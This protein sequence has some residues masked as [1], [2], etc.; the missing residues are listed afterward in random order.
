[1]NRLLLTSSFLLLTFLTFAKKSETVNT[2]KHIR[3]SK[4]KKEIKFNNDRHS[5]ALIKINSGN[6]FIVSPPNLVYFEYTNV[7]EIAEKTAGAG[8][9]VFSIVEVKVSG[10]NINSPQTVTFDYSSST[11]TIDE[12]FSTD[13]TS[14]TFDKDGT[15]IITL[16]IFND[17]IIEDTESIV[18]KFD[19][20]TTDPVQNRIAN[21]IITDDDYVPTIGIAAVEVS[22]EEFESP[23][24]PAGWE[25][26]SILETEPNVW[27]FDG[28]T[29]DTVGKAYISAG[30]AADGATYNSTA[31]GNLILISDLINAKGFTNVTISFD[32][33]AGG[34]T[35][36]VD[37]ES[38]FD[39][40]TFVY[41]YDGIN[42]ISMSNFA[43]AASG[44][45]PSSGNYNK[46]ITELDDAQF[47]LGWRWINDDL[48]GTSFSFTI[49]NVVVSA[50]PA[51]VAAV[52]DQSETKRVKIGSQIY[53]LDAEDGD[54][55]GMIENAD[56]DLNCVTLTVSE[57]GS[58]AEF[59]NIGGTHSGK[60]IK[61]ETDAATASYDLTLF[62]TDAEVNQLSGNDLSVIK[63]KVNGNAIDDAS[64]SANNF[65][66]STPETMVY[67]EHEYSTYKGT[68][69]G[70]GTYALMVEETLSTQSVNADEFKIYPTVL[71]ADKAI[72]IISNKTAID[73]VDIY[74]INGTLMSSLELESRNKAQVAVSKLT[75]GMYFLVINSNRTDSYKFLIK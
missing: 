31:F 30:V 9:D 32:W 43:G 41:S 59:T 37:S 34:E 51:S 2:E 17:G 71:T 49:D 62:F 20:N 68:Y 52:L 21:Y 72:N 1:M 54:V 58:A 29:P 75:S 53:F 42:F 66:I 67:V 56:E 25:T 45:A 13:A 55:I 11:A 63:V 39:Y 61:V 19:V 27:R 64:S 70:S 6:E 46:A 40:G 47:Y 57:T 44:A 74:A 69:T 14:F 26:R 22:R 23:D 7:Y 4:N 48:L 10:R 8:C 16:K 65:Q 5:P 38:Y 73:H 24:I 50:T 35:D 18:I 3:L 28:P 60:V 36:Q 33:E 12:D 15:K